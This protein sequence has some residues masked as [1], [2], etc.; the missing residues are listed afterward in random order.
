MLVNDVVG[1]AIVVTGVIV[2]FLELA[3]PGALLFIPGS[4]LIAGGFLYLFLP[5]VLL[6]SPVGPI[7]IVLVA[8]VAG[9]LE[10]PY[11]R[12]VAPPHL[13][14]TTTSAGLAGEVGIVTVP[15]V[16]HTLRGKI[17]VKSE[18]WS[19]TAESSIPAGTRVRVVSGEGVSLIVAPISEP[20]SAN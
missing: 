6:Q 13:P 5:D 9:I 17:R 12:W 1:I 4:I 18:V 2:L 20:T 3:H 10:I 19:A 7:V 14:M 16:P 15:I 11:Y 8:A